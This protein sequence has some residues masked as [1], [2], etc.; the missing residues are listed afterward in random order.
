MHAKQGNVGF[1]RWQ[2]TTI[3]RARDFHE[4]PLKTPGDNEAK[5]KVSIRYA[6]PIPNRFCL[7]FNKRSACRTEKRG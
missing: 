2:R 4:A 1:G 6:N 7:R 3:P 5:E